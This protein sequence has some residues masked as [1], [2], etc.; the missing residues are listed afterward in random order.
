MTEV[1]LR[2]DARQ[3]RG[4][5]LPARLMVS[6]IFLDVSRGLRMAYPAPTNRRRDLTLIRQTL[7]KDPCGAN[8][9]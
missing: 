5:T 9:G 4:I 7:V 6:E 1:L 8:A 3:V 2:R